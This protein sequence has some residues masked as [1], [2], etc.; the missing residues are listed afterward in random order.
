MAT[1]TV[2]NSAGLMS[3]LKS[4]HG[5]DTILLA[6]GTYSAVSIYQFHPTSV[7][8]IQSASATNQAVITALSVNQSSNLK[9]TNITFTTSLYNAPTSTQ[10]P[11]P[12]SVNSS[13]NIS[14]NKIT[15]YDTLADP[16]QAVNGFLIKGSAIISVTN[17]TFHNF[18]NAI[19][20]LNNTNVVISNNTF[21]DL[22]SDGIDNGG[23]SNVVISGNSFTNFDSVGPI[24]GAGDHPDCIQFWTSNTTTDASNI[25]VSNNTYVRGTGNWAQGIFITDQVGL[26]YNNVT[27]TGNTIIGAAGN[28]IEIM[29][30]H[31]VNVSNNTVEGY[32]DYANFIRLENDTGVT[33]N[34]NTTPGFY[35]VNTSF[36]SQLANQITG[37]V[38]PVSLAAINVASPITA[39]AETA[40]VTEHGVQN[41]SALKGDAGSALY[42]ADVGIDP[43]HQKIVAA[44]GTTFTGTYGTLTV[45]S[46][47]T[48][49]YTETAAALTAGQVY[50]D[51]FTLTVANT[52]GGV[53]TSTLDVV[54]TGSSVGDG[55]ADTIYAGSGAETIS[56]FGAKSAL[57]SGTGPDTF[58]FGANTSTPTAQTVIQNFKAGDVIDL[59]AIDPNFQIV[60]KLDHHA[61]EL[62]ILPTA[63]AG[64]WEIY[65]DTTGSGTPDFQI[66]LINSSIAPTAANFHL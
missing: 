34:N 7:V 43:T 49:T 5:G 31:N 54:V 33:A 12:F 56:G 38:A 36:I 40:S 4:A 19:T 15:A 20:E 61:N 53:A 59:A 2:N 6:S 21:H 22:R 18:Y 29:S 58:V 42:L 44:A 66:H 55:G 28:A 32:A 35:L 10:A 30:G 52:S 1:V 23:S 64:G 57:Y 11:S 60:S 27:V 25:V 41:G 65:G 17:S 48:Y 63:I 16:Q 26:G 46:N 8:N 13:S 47:G 45:H 9:F 14:F 3:A 39:V 24:L 37:L 50:D 51:H 62:V